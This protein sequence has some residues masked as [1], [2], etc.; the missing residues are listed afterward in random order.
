MLLSG[1]V[2]MTLVSAPSAAVAKGAAGEYLVYV[3]TYTGQKSKGIYAYRFNA[4]TGSVT[5]LG[6]AG[7]TANPSF[8]AIHPRRKYLYAVNEVDDFAGGHTGA[9]SAFALD[10]KT[11]KLTFLNRVASRGAYPCYLVVDSTGQN[12]LVAN[13]GSGTVAVIRLAKDGHLG[14]A[15]SVIQHSGSSVD[16]ARQEGPHAHSINLSADNRFAIAADL[17]L[18]ELLV[19]RFDAERGTLQATNPP[20]AKVNPGAGPRHF[21]FHPSGRFA[22]VISEMQSTVTAF[23]YDPARG[24]LREL[25]TLSTLPEGF[26]GQND[27]AEVRVHP[28]GKFLYGS[29]RGPDS[30]A[31]YTIDPERGTLTPA[32]HTSTQG[33]TPRNFNLDPTGTYLFAANQD[34]DNVVIFR[35]DPGTGHLTP[36]G[37]VL[38]VP[39]PV[40]VRFVPID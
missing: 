32:G 6:V 29:N 38:S 26:A 14:A 35:V 9:V 10:A 12:V 21:A 18:D 7:E 5:A 1:F 23:A 3:G 11:G 16:R 8:L 30:I 33:K 22:Y 17:G 13:Y 27:A 24:A 4:R 25:Q 19:Y 28:S 15:S 36:T 20:F 40:C 2:L 37:Q 39:S 31:L 34:T